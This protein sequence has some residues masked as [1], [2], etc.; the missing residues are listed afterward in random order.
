MQNGV[1]RIKHKE[2]FSF[3]KAASATFDLSVQAALNPG[4][5]DLF[6]WLNVLATCFESYKFRDI[7]FVWRPSCP[8][9]TTGRI[10]VVVDYNFDDEDPQ[11]LETCLTY[12]DSVI[13]SP[14]IGFSQKLTR[15]NLRKRASYYVATATEVI[16]DNNLYHTGKVYLVRGGNGTD[17][18]L[19]LGSMWI[20]YDVELFT[21]KRS[22]LAV[23]MLSQ[24][25][26]AI[27]TA[28]STTLD[29]TTKFSEFLNSP[30]ANKY[31]SMFRNLRWAPD[32]RTVSLLHK[33][34]V[35]NGIYYPSKK[36]WLAVLKAKLKPMLGSDGKPLDGTRPEHFDLSK[37][38]PYDADLSLM[39]ITPRGT[40]L[41]KV[42]VDIAVGTAL[43][44]QTNFAGLMTYT[45]NDS[46]PAF[47]FQRIDQNGGASNS[48]MLAMKVE[49]NTMYD[50][51][52]DLQI[53]SGSSYYLAS[54][55][56][57]NQTA[58]WFW[59]SGEGLVRVRLT[60]FFKVRSEIGTVFY[61][62][63]SSS[64]A[65]TTGTSGAQHSYSVDV[66][67]GTQVQPFASEPSFNLNKMKQNE[68]KRLAEKEYMYALRKEMEKKQQELR[69]KPQQTCAPTVNKKWF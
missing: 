16:V 1:M 54:D 67:G 61:P 39:E 47:Y 15:R 7:R 31:L 19:D 46:F 49:S 13:G 53:A 51:S 34:R 23:S 62:V 59:G 28:A 38:T 50:D 25:F 32:V 12:D 41:V 66:F 6:P 45:V 29:I 17:T 27:S 30:T 22:E 43:S 3:A 14:Y 24:A 58:F 42:T 21:P 52:G 69:Q 9:T 40:Q 65:I 33:N 26:S 10:G 57:D 18:S 60:G 68:M 37:L 11:D 63:L 8:T 44:L 35:H 48:E 20:E 5:A 55:S 56:V 64:L 4:N 36:D 2:V